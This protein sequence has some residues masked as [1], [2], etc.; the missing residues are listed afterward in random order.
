MDRFFI[1]HNLMVLV[2]SVKKTQLRESWARIEWSRLFL[3]RDLFMF[4]APSQLSHDT[5]STKSQND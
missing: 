2:M 3:D 1:H 5:D 4:F